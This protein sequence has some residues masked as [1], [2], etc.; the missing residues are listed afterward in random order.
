MDRTLVCREC[1]ASFAF[2]QG[3]QEF[4]Q[5]R[6]LANPPSRC[7]K[8]RAA[9]KAQLGISTGVPVARAPQEARTL[10]PATCARCGKPTQVPFQPRGDRPVYC[11]DCFH[12]ERPAYTPSRP[13]FVTTPSF[14]EAPPEESR[15]ERKP[16]RPADRYEQR[17][18]RFER[19]EPREHR[20]TRD[21]LALADSDDE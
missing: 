15:R 2:T 13:S 12:A 9:R 3:E 1:G 20:R 18:D 5:S 6:G 8:C 21:W 19:A 11:S 10:Y 16:R 14:G 7:P 4:Y 17:S